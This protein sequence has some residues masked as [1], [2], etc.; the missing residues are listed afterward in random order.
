VDVGADVGLQAVTRTRG[1]LDRIG[2]RG[3]DDLL[4]DRLFA[5]N[6]IR[7]LQEL[8]PVCTDCHCRLLGNWS[9][10]SPDAQ[11]LVS[12]LSSSG[13]A[14]AAARAFLASLSFFSV[15]LM[16]SSVRISLAS[17]I[18]SHGMRTT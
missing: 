7:D 9:G 6:R 12:V 4:V 11:S 13:S 8:Q 1:L 3:D 16:R 15:S 2:H 18:A 10:L 17:A 5:R 14:S